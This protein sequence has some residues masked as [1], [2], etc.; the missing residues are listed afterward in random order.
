MEKLLVF[1]LLFIIKTTFIWS[2]TFDDLRNYNHPEFAK[3]NSDINEKKSLINLDCNQFAFFSEKSTNWFYLYT[4]IQKMIAKK[5]RKLNFYHIGGSHIQADIYTHDFRT[6]LQSNWPGLDGERGLV[7][8]FGLASTNNPSNYNFSSPNNWTGFRSVSARP[9]DLQY[10]LT[11]AAIKCADSLIVVN[12][13]HMRSLVKPP[14]NRL[15]IY[16]NTGEFFY[17]MNF[18]S[19]E[20]FVTD[21]YHHADLGYSEIRFSDK[22]DSLDIQFIRTCNIATSLEIYGF[23][24]LND[25]PGIT[26]NAIGINGAGLYTYLGNEH[27]LRD[28]KIHPPDFFAFSLGTNDAYTSYENFNPQKYKENLEDMIKLILTVNPKC[29]I[30]LTVPNDCL[31]NKKHINKNTNRQREVI[32]QLAAKYE[33]AVWDFYGIMGELGSSKSWKEN[34][35]M[36]TDYVHFTAGG[37]HIKGSLLIDAFLKYLLQF[38]T[39][40]ELKKLN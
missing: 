9:E 17:D 21:T 4:E 16:H 12:F 6:F 32:Y 31:L 25:L 8:P 24:F 14:F 33:Q 38:D 1:I 27:F 22:M 5:D 30:L 15:R 36:Q 39:L 34:G 20:L 13:K 26:Y 37:Y 10:G 28:L 2:Q 40:S 19:Q 7:F 11:G 23:E 18:G 35:L 29:A 3:S